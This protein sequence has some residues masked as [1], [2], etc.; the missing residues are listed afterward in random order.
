MRLPGV[1]HLAH[2]SFGLG[3]KLM[4]PTSYNSPP[5]AH[6]FRLLDA[7]ESIVRLLMILTI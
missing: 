2:R 4:C 3:A 1:P 6:A 7:D 5:Y